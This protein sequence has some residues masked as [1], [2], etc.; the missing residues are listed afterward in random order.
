MQTPPGATAS[1]APPTVAPSPSRIRQWLTWKPAI[2]H[3]A[4][5][6]AALVVAGFALLASALGFPLPAGVRLKELIVMAMI[7]GIGLTVALF[8]AGEAFPDPVRQDAAKMGALASALIAPLAMGLG[9]LLAV[10]PRPP[11]PAP[12]KAT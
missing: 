11:S 5:L 4:L 10:K 1:S 3:R 8:V 6:L 2:Q 12:L 7:A 9:R